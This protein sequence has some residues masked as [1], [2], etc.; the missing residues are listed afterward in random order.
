MFI[1]LKDV[2]YTYNV[3]MPFETEAI[4]SINLHIGKGE[5]VGII[6]HTG[7]GKT[8]L[9]QLING[10]LEPT[11]GN[12][13]ID[14]I[15]IHEKKIKLKEIRKRIGLTFQ[16]PENQLFE[17]SVYKEIAFGP[18]NMGIE[19]GQLKNIIE[20]ALAMVKLDF[21]IYKERSPFSLSGGEM[22]RIAIASVLAIDPEVVILDEPTAN[23]DPKNRNVI[24]KLIQELHQKHKKTIILVSHNMELIAELAQRVLVMEKGKIILDDK[25]RNIFR[26]YAEKIESIGMSLPQVT[27]IVRKL[28]EMGKPVSIDILTVEEASEEIISLARHKN[29]I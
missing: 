22:R 25:P 24:L 15:N 19:E 5:F 2:S 12:V 26:F 27:N 18:R 20:K 14:D 11:K 16:Y 9:L 4:K 6:G 1:H 7:C 3:N 29:H 13:L 8:T 17:E 28:N 10:L 23:L 21:N